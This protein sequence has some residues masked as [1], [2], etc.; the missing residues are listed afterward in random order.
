VGVRFIRG[1]IPR[2]G[3]S[4]DFNELNTVESCGFIFRLVNG[5]DKLK[6]TDA[7]DCDVGDVV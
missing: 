5:A 4:F 3:A 6:S 2:D 7:C 1:E